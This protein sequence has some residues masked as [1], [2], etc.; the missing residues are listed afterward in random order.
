MCPGHSTGDV[1]AKALAIHHGMMRSSAYKGRVF[2]LIKE[3]LTEMNILSGRDENQPKYDLGVLPEEALQ[4]YDTWQRRHDEVPAKRL[5]KM[6]PRRALLKAAS[7]QRSS[8]DVDI[9][10]AFFSTSRH[11]CC[12]ASFRATVRVRKISFGTCEEAFRSSRWRH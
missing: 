7:K 3:T 10:A 9:G 4:L 5:P 1:V 8:M 6:S 12:L 2:K 11:C